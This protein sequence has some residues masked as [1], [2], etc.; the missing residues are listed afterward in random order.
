MPYDLLTLLLS[1]LGTA[2]CGLLLAAVLALLRW[3]RV[4][5]LAAALSL[6][7]LWVFA[8]PV[9]AHALREDLGSAYPPVPA[10]AL[11]EAGAI[12]ILGGG[13]V[14]PAAGQPY[15]HLADAADRV[16][17][18]ARLYHA[19]RAPLIVTSGGFNPIH[20]DAP[21]ALAM[22]V[23][24]RD[25]GVPAANILSE[26]RSRS[27]RENAAFTAALLRMRGIDHILLVTSAAH[28]PRALPLFEAQGLRVVPA[29]TDHGGR[30]RAGWTRF[31]PNARALADSGDAVKEY[32]GRWGR[33]LGF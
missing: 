8:L 12:V 26:D 31:L 22:G 27:T 6:L 23:F 1:P 14:P 9:T 3:R 30:A 2:C 25:L 15:P 28:M 11:P 17:H 5:A 4:A 16:W 7:W 21:E 20:A 32:L 18:G 29:A 19:G 33:R 13:M 10:A 24:L